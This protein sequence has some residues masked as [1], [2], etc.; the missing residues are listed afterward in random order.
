MNIFLLYLYIRYNCFINCYFHSYQCMIALHNDLNATR[1]N[2]SHLIFYT[3][4]PYRF[5]IKPCRSGYLYVCNNK[6]YRQFW[7]HHVFIFFE[8]IFRFKF[9]NSIYFL[10]LLHLVI[11]SYIENERGGFGKTLRQN[12]RETHHT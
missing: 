1:I 3:E 12:I 6:T 2:I 8:G 7:E 9:H 11:D 10:C 5:W 4:C